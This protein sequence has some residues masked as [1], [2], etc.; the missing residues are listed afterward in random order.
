MQLTDGYGLKQ[1]LYGFSRLL[2]FPSLF[3][4]HLFL[5]LDLFLPPVRA[6]VLG[7]IQVCKNVLFPA[8]CPEEGASLSN[9]DETYR[10]LEEN[11]RSSHRCHPSPSQGQPIGAFFLIDQSKSEQLKWLQDCFLNP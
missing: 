6:T 3:F 9:A 1:P 5:M 7:S 4:T 2:Y 8:V 11:F 10:H